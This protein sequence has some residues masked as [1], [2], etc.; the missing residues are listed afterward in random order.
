[1]ESNH[2][3][4]QLGLSQLVWHIDDSKYK[5]LPGPNARH[6]GVSGLNSA[7]YKLGS[8]HIHQYLF[9]FMHMSVQLSSR[10][11]QYIFPCWISYIGIFSEN[12]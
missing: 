5:L 11:L 7:T 12:I 3:M 10:I 2:W 1:M 9:L 8:T 4:H 6:F